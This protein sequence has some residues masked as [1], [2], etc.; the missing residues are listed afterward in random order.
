MEQAEYIA[1]TTPP[2]AQSSA[3]RSAPRLSQKKLTCTLCFMALTPVV[4]I[5][6]LQAVLPPVK[7]GVLKAEVTLRNVPPRSFFEQ[8]PSERPSLPRPSVVIKNVGDVDWTH[9]NIRLNRDYQI[10][11]HGA[12]FPPGSQ[13]SYLLDQFIS[14][15]GTK[16]DVARIQLTDI[17]IYARLPNRSRATFDQ[18]F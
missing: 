10:Y 9:I 7:P 5:I 3:V 17:E 18:D 4:T 15:T 8:D 1:P 13:R 16:L 2:I 12:P 11:E 6:W 14:R